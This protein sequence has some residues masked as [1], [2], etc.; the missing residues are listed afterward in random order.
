MADIAQRLDIRDIAAVSAWLSTQRLP[1][2]THAVAP[3]ATP[4]PLQCG[5]A[6][7][8]KGGRP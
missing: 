2:N 3:S 8:P 1:A 4:L 5:S 7:P 6:M